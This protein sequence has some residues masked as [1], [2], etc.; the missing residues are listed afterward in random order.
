MDCPKTGPAQVR[1]KTEPVFPAEILQPKGSE[2]TDKKLILKK[3]N[4]IRDLT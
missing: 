3:H 4:N 2:K 1:P